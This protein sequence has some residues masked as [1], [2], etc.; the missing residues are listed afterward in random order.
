MAMLGS[1][2]GVLMEGLD[3]DNAGVSRIT[4]LVVAMRS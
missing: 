4:S 1:I 2:N 3:G